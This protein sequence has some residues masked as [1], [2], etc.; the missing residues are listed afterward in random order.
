MDVD[1]LQLAQ[2]LK[3]SVALSND[4]LKRTITERVRLDSEL[5]V[6][7]AMFP[8]KVPAGQAIRVLKTVTSVSK[9]LGDNTQVEDLVDRRFIASAT[10]LSY[11]T[12]V[13]EHSTWTYDGSP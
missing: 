2:P 6:E 7:C 9:A 11:F 8:S 1:K 10:G 5:I 12:S 4:F 13:S 3:N